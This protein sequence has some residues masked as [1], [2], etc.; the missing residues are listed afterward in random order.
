M[1]SISVFNG[2][3]SSCTPKSSKITSLAA[4]TSPMPQSLVHGCGSFK[5][6]GV[7][8]PHHSLHQAMVQ[9]ALPNDQSGMVVAADLAWPKSGVTWHTCCLY[10]YFQV[11]IYITIPVQ[12]LAATRD[13]TS[14]NGKSMGSRATLGPADLC[15]PA[16]ART[17]QL[18]RSWQISIAVK[19]CA[20][21]V[22]DEHL[23]DHGNDS[24]IS[25][26]VFNDAFG[27]EW[28]KRCIL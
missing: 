9:S 19:R 14:L 16:A 15:S 7:V 23:T 13:N 17:L 10:R 12:Q 26:Y 1:F 4:S 11:Y 5:E 2:F 27:N 28:F 18:L 21:S 8:Q 20:G 3:F 6:T 22:A 25:K 24:N